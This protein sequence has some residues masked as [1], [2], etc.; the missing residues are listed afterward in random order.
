MRVACWRDPDRAA[1]S[2]TWYA[3]ERG[4]CRNATPPPTSKDR[5]LIGSVLAK[6]FGTKNEREIKR[7]QPLVD[8]INALEAE[9]QKLTDEQLRAK[10]QE[11]KQRIQDNLEAELGA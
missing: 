4:C 7:I 9:I 11:F 8:R 2:N 6:V 5:T 1:A 10:T 3:F